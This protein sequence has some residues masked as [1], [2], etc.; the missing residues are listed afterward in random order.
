ME[1]KL[2]QEK[3][4]K[5]K[6]F[7]LMKELDI[8]GEFIY[9]GIASFNQMDTISSDSRLFSF[10]YYISVGI[11]R[12]EKIILVL[13]EK[14]SQDAYEEF[15]KKIK[16]HDHETLNNI[17]SNK[18]EIGLSKREIHLLQLLS[19]FYN[20]ARYKRFEI[21]VDKKLEQEIVSEFIRNHME[22]KDIFYCP[23]VSNI[24]V[25][26]E[27]KTLFGRIVGS[28]SKKYYEFI[29]NECKKNNLYSY[30]LRIGSKA[31]KIFLNQERKNSLNKI[32][33]S[34]SIALKELIIYLV[35]AK[36]DDSFI[37]FLKSINPLDLDSA[38]V[39]NYLGDIAKG[40]IP[41]SLID[42]VETMYEENAEDDERMMLLDLIGD[43]SLCF[44]FDE[45]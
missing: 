34:E 22:E 14:L 41:Q 45:Q 5:I 3:I 15:F 4:W 38:L 32:K 28:I 26:V 35:N 19:K 11:E 27:V 24:I 16:T 18:V 21:E 13:T 23:W 8:A 25:T 10:L 43:E 9:D 39:N 37:K 7:N 2:T 12:L 17:I 36:E 30:E 20:L 44:D 31:E 42:E 33:N 1:K 40:I 6:N 29:K